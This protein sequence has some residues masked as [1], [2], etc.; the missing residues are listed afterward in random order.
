MMS[1][2]LENLDPANGMDERAVKE[3]GAVAYLGNAQF[4]RARG[5]LSTSRRF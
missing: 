5:I 4:G 2:G 1:L 3:A